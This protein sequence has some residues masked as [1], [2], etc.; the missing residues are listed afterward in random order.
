MLDRKKKAS[1]KVK[2]NAA[3][4]FTEW[5]LQADV[6]LPVPM[7][8]ETWLTEGS[9]FAAKMIDDMNRI[10]KEKGKTGRVAPMQ[11]CKRYTLDLEISEM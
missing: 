9:D 1:S 6:P 2:T 7:H 5:F 11:R 3:E 8:Y 10:M 4:D